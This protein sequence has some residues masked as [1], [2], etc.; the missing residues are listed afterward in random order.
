VLNPF[1]IVHQSL[2]ARNMCRRVNLIALD[3]IDTSVRSV[4]NVINV[5]FGGS[6]DVE[7]SILPTVSGKYSSATMHALKTSLV[8]TETNILS[9][10]P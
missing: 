2:C 4:I 5:I 9:S 1:E 8:I 3:I 6:R 10:S 7:V